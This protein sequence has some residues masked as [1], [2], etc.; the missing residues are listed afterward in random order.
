MSD[1]PQGPGWWLATDGRW[2][3]PQAPVP[4][5]T[6][7]TAPPPPLPGGVPTGDPDIGETLT[8]AW[9]KIQE[10]PAPLLLTSLAGFVLLVVIGVMG[11]VAFLASVFSAAP[12]ECVRYSASTGRCV[13][14]EGGSS[15][16]WFLVVWLGMVVALSFGQALV[17]FFMIRLGLLVTA[18]EPL[19]VGSILS[20]KRFASYLIGA[21]VLGLLAA[22][23][24]VLCIVP[25]LAVLAFGR[26]FGYYVMDKGEGPI[27]AI[28]SSFRFV[29]ENLGR[30]LLFLLVTVGIFYA[31]AQICYV[32][33]IA[34]LPF[35]A[36]AT[37]YFYK[38]YDGQH[39]APAIA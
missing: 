26:F 15:N 30:V 5:A 37:T 16:G 23:G 38:R 39:V 19:T 8:Y 27:Q 3:P 25:G 31:G 12:S 21:V 34:A 28:N 13:D 14:Y 33:L 35:N 18:G 7:A 10:H 36:V 2:Y 24:L 29:R 11:Y 9:K 6:W 17:D 1:T 20:L 32:G 22:I 4:Q